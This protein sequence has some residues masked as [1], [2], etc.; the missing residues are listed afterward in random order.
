MLH[1]VERPDILRSVYHF[2]KPLTTIY[3]AFSL[4]QAQYVDFILPRTRS[5]FAQASGLILLE[6]GAAELASAQKLSGQLGGL[7]G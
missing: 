3:C 2:V 5:D 4:G 6:L 7:V 1:L